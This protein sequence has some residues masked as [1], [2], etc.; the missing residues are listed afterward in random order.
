MILSQ[1]Q[2]LVDFCLIYLASEIH[3]TCP[4]KPKFVERVRIYELTH[5][6]TYLVFKDQLSSLLFPS[7]ETPDYT[8][9]VFVV[10]HSSET[11][12]TFSFLVKDVPQRQIR[13]LYIALDF[14]KPGRLGLKQNCFAGRPT[15]SSLRISK[16]LH[17]LGRKN[18]PSHPVVKRTGL[19]P[20]EYVFA[21][22]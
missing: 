10:K 5:G 22:F 14:V 18:R 3:L 4:N 12:L 1:D 21:R 19:P 6:P 11:F 7:S 2:T 13:N 20:W 17:I 9:A 8:E 15:M 16:T